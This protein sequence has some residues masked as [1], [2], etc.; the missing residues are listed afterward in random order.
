MKRKRV[1]LIACSMFLAGSIMESCTNL[2]K[3]IYSVTPINDFYQNPAQ[4]QPVLPLLIMPCK[5]FL[6]AMCRI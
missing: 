5:E 1:L 4:I 6:T 2:D 3:K